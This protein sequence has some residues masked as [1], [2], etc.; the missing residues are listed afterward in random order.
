MCAFSSFRLANMAGHNQQC[1]VI[2]WRYNIDDIYYNLIMFLLSLRTLSLSS[3]Q[4]WKFLVPHCIF[5]M[6]LVVFINYTF[7]FPCSQFLSAPFQSLVTVMNM[8]IKF[9]PCYFSVKCSLFYNLCA[10]VLFSFSFHRT[11]Y[12]LNI[13][14]NWGLNLTS[15]RFNPQLWQI[16]SRS[17][18]ACI[19]VM[20]LVDQAR[21]HFNSFS[22]STVHWFAQLAE[23]ITS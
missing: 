8:L 2:F 10:Y 4:S 17:E 11:V 12:S 18:D 22:L 7:T 14:H 21:S 23:M 9:I 6:F 19:T 3:D 15:V 5:S 16:L 13:C 1:E 20:P